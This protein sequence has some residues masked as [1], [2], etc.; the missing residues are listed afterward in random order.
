MLEPPVSWVQW[1]DWACLFLAMWLCGCVRDSARLPVSNGGQ[2]LGG[3]D[4][5]ERSSLE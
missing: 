5:V 2:E 1:E 4:V 3:V